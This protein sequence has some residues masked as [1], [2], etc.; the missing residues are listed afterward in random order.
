MRSK[1]LLVTVLLIV[2][3]LQDITMLAMAQSPSPSDCFVT[4]RGMTGCMESVIDFFN[5]AGTFPG[6]DC[7][8][9]VLQICKSCWVGFGI[10]NQA[11]IAELYS[12]CSNLTNPV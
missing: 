1:Q 7:C 4:L 9:A 10:H 2:A 11:V 3:M 8:K 6:P 12:F 5:N